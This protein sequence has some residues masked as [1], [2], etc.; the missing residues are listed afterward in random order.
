MTTTEKEAL[1]NY[2]EFTLTTMVEELESNK[3][4]NGQPQVGAVYDAAYEML[5]EIERTLND[6]LELTNQEQIKLTK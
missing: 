2:L 1:L 3:I 4:I 6:H 5:N